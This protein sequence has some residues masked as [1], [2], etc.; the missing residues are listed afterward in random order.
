ML[1]IIVFGTR[2]DPHVVWIV[3]AL[4]K[5]HAVEATLLDY[6]QSEFT[7]YYDRSGY[8]RLTIDGREFTRDIVVFDRVKLDVGSAFYFPERDPETSHIRAQR[9]DEWRALY[10]MLCGTARITLNGLA[11]RSCMAKPFQQVHAAKCGFLVPETVVSNS[12]RSLVDHLEKWGGSGVLKSL[13]G[14]IIRMDP[15][16]DRKLRIFM[17]TPVAA[18]EVSAAEDAAF[19][20]CPTFA[21]EEVAK[22]YE[23][24]V[25][26]VNGISLP[27]RINSQDYR[28]TS[29]D[30]R[31]S[32]DAL[33]FEPH[34]LPEDVLS[35]VSG[36]MRAMG[37]FCGALDFIIDRN[38]DLWFLECNQQ[39]AWGWLDVQQDGQ[40]R[41]LF[42]EQIAKVAQFHHDAVLEGLGL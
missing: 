23:L 36:F 25:I 3:E 32:T 21:Q 22:A 18:S 16:D 17:T 35:K 12:K 31:Y 15:A 33:R 26:W 5:H 38:G 7:A 14:S 9:A 13:S 42:A 27:F 29:L 20:I 6:E 24:R 10:R 8:F 19:S 37:L 28:T 39:G 30:W 2:K 34:I 1:P 41:R 40:I 11:A 4:A